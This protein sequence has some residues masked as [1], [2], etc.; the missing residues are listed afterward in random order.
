[1]DKK[2]TL[3]GIALPLMLNMLVSQIQL[4]ID[5]S[6][7]G[8]IQ[9][10]YMSA[11][12]N[13][14]APLWTTMGLIFSLATGATVLMS[15][16]IGAKNLEEVEEM[17]HSSLKFTTLFSLLIFFLWLFGA[18]FIFTLMGVKEPVL[19]FCLDYIYFLLPMILGTGIFSGCTSIMQSVGYTRPI[20]IAGVVR[21]LLNLI[22]DWLLIF[23]NW[24]FPEM[25]I[26]GAA[27]ATSIAEFIGLVL[28]LFILIRSSEIPFQIRFSKVIQGKIGP[29]IKA[30]KKGLPA[31]GEEFLWN[32]GNL[33]LIRLLNVISIIAAGIHTIVFS[34]DILPA[35]MFVSLGQG[36][37]TLTGHAIG[38]KKIDDILKPGHQG[39]LHSSVISVL[40]LLCFLFIPRLILGIFTA[41]EDIINQAV[42]LLVIA[43]INFFP[44][45]VNIVTGF[46]IRGYGDTQWMM[47]TQILGTIQVLALSATFIFVLDWGIKGVFIAVLLDETIRA[48]INYIRFRKGPKP[49]AMEEMA[50]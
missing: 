18:R 24:G 28:L 23:G 50:V 10:E 7:L 8:Q 48:I 2:R 19:G 27:L 36:V 44:R 3:W 11:L 22:L 34:V 32:L 20:L 41:D 46:A 13:V 30:A 17:A 33:G 49:E 4:M 15:Q 31:A 39:L 29:F 26:R 43:G 42:P 35:L 1:M 5:R 14:T 9:V 16:G 47:Y 25:G 12:G 6:F 38:E 45:S 40:V 21:S 37:M